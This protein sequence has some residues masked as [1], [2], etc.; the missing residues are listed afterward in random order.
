MITWPMFQAVQRQSEIGNASIY[1]S[2]FAYMGTFTES[3][4]TGVPIYY[5]MSSVIVS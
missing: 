4:K 1:F 5:G 3:F 2:F